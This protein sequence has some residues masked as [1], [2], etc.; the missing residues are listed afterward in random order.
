MN[1]FSEVEMRI[2]AHYLISLC[3]FARKEKP[4]CD[5]MSGIPLFELISH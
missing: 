2:L 3:Y 4:D 5:E 1:Q